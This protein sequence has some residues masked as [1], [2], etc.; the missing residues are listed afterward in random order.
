MANITI[1]V[2]LL[3]DDDTYEIVSKN[4]DI[5]TDEDTIVEA[6][7][8]CALTTINE[9]VEPTD[10]YWYQEDPDTYVVCLLTDREDYPTEEDAIAD[11]V[12]HA[13]EFIYNLKTELQTS[14]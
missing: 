5:D 6:F 7:T 4:F 3:T 13:Q 11:A 2:N 8:Q 9:T 12:E 1:Q 14:L 10:P